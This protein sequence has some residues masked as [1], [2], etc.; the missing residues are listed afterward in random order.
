VL[1]EQEEVS[2]DLELTPE[3]IREGD[4][5]AF[6]RALADARKTMDLSPKDSV[7]V[8][9]DESAR[10]ILENVSIPGTSALAFAALPD[11]PY[12]ADLSIGKIGFAVTLDAA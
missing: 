6:M 9:A 3:L 1:T 2:L 12:S 10:A 5:R 7:S 4:V 8:Q 11:A